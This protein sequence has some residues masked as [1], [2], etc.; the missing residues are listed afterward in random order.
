[1]NRFTYQE[2]ADMHLAYGAADESGRPARQ[3]YEDR[4][5]NRKIP[6][7]EMFARMHRNLCER[8]SLRSNMQD[9]GRRRLT[10]T[11]NVAEQV[12]QCIEGNRNTST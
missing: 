10:R 11:V 12:L 7:H 5:P 6:Q 8:D 2:L 1:M 9:T 3:V 4:Y